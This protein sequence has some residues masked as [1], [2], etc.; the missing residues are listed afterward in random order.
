M[1]L[2]LLSG[3]M[4]SSTLLAFSHAE[5]ACFID[6]GQRHIKELESAQAIAEHYQVPLYEL[7]LREFGRSVESALTSAGIEVPEGHYAAEN[8]AITVVPNRNAVLL[9]CAAGIAA[10]KGLGRVLTAVHAGDHAIYPDCREDFINA[11]DKATH[12]ACGVRIEAPFVRLDKS[13]I[14]RLAGQMGVP[15]EAT[16]SCYKGGAQHC[17][18]CGTCVER[19]EAIDAAGLVDL[20]GYADAEFW[21]TA[22]A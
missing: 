17:G 9:S 8:M 15:L 21:K 7:S 16:W 11:I 4:D 5:A 19:I 6:Y 12:L 18:R 13:D 14:A 3:G 22:R 2:A 10:S 1:T 20:T